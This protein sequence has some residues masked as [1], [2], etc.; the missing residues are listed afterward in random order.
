[1]NSFSGIFALALPSCHHKSLRDNNETYIKLLG[2]HLRRF[3]NS[4]FELSWKNLSVVRSY[5]VIVCVCGCVYA[6][7]ITP[8]RLWKGVLLTQ[9]I[10]G[11]IGTQRWEIYWQAFT[12][13]IALK[14]N[15][16]FKNVFSMIF[17]YTYGGFL[18]SFKNSVFYCYK[19]IC[20]KFSGPTLNSLVNIILQFSFNFSHFKFTF[21][22][23]GGK[24][25]RDLYA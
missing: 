17:A 21:M 22:K 9:R 12:K 23:K 11:V 14:Q 24:M 4:K 18:T 5:R 20:Y 15:I 13:Y 2:D 10:Y 6:R 25:I 3:I 7:P 1:M 19:F 16:M 8:W